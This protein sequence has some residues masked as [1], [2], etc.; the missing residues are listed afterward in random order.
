LARG[1]PVVEALQ[2]TKLFG[3]LPAKELR[4]VRQAGKELSFAAGE[5]LTTEGEAGGRYFLILD[6]AADMVRGG[7]VMGRLG[8]GDGFGEIALLDGGPRT[9]TVVAATQ[10]RTF[11][12]A[13]W[14]FRPLVLEQ[15]AIAGSVISTLCA[16]LRETEAERRAGAQPGAAPD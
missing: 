11:S 10:L 13:S 9:A 4:H 5:D 14:N 1:D 7:E 2:R 15:P 12:L 3:A 6:G 8:P 16:W